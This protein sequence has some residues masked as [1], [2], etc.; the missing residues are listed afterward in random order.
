MEWSEL[1]SGTAGGSVGAASPDLITVLELGSGYGGC[2][3]AL[4]SV[5]WPAAREDVPVAAG[6]SSQAVPLF[7]PVSRPRLRRFLVLSEDS[8]GLPDE[9][10]VRGDD[11]GLRGEPGVRDRSEPF[12]DVSIEVVRERVERQEYVYRECE[13][14]ATVGGRR[15]GL[16]LGLDPGS[17]DCSWWQWCQ[18]ERLWSGPLVEAWR[19][20]GFIPAYSVHRRGGFS[21]D[22]FTSLGRHLVEECGDVLHGDIFLLVWRSGVLQLTCHFKAGYFHTWPKPIR[23]FPLVAVSGLRGDFGETEIGEQQLCVGQPGD[24]TLDFAPAG[25]M[26]AG[27]HRAL[28]RPRDSL[29][30]IQPWTDLRVFAYKSK[31][32]EL[33]NLEPDDPSVKP[34]G[35][36]RSF[37]F[38]VSLDGAD[39]RVGRYRV[40]PSMY[41]A[42]GVLETSRIGPAVEMASRS[43]TLQKEY[44]QRGGFDTGRVW[45]HLR[46]DLRT[47]A[48][49]Q[50]GADWDGN[51]AQGLFTFAYQTGEWPDQVWQLYLQQAYHAA[52]VAVYHGSWMCRLE[53]SVA[54]SAPLSKFRFGGPLVA[55]LETGDPYLLEVCRSLAGVYMAMEYANQPRSAMGR[56]AYPLTSV[57]SLWDYTADDLYLSFARQAALRLVRTQH[58]DGGFSGQAGA[59]TYTG[60]SSVPAEE[61]IG[62]GNGLLAPLGLLEWAVR[63]RELPDAVRVAVERWV[64]LMLRLQTDDG[65]WLNKSKGSFYSL[66]GAAALYSLVKAGELLGDERCV[67][68]VDR[69]LTAMNNQHDGVL[70]THSFLAPLYAHVADAALGALARPAGGTQPARA[71]RMSSS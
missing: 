56:D 11:L 10:E 69:F 5:P 53:G 6:V 67:R 27:S 33:L 52:D 64:E 28:V 54:F 18:A 66:I 50:D 4:T 63:D 35:V 47:G 39:P 40:P 71:P 8:G 36:S 70:G 42:C 31:D 29:T 62:F 24:D 12:S 38:T 14:V 55:Y 61:H 22:G 32:N 9:L 43:V 41:E 2:Q 45:R 51:L 30:T 21:A 3:R 17:G 16:R 7:A 68:A 15:L 26:F 49:Q 60:I 34:A 19:V 57:L 65:L 1:E 46:W 20:G 23:A 13:A 59:G 37:W 58:P 48:A 44:T 25:L